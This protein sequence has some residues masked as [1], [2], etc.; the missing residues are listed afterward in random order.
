MLYSIPDI[1]A[2]VPLAYIAYF[3][4]PNTFDSLEDIRAVCAD[5]TDYEGQCVHKM[6]LLSRRT[7][8]YT[9]R[10]LGSTYNYITGED[11]VSFR[12]VTY[13]FALDVLFV[14]TY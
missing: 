1:T 14:S 10:A 7:W 11:F 4:S 3:S 5:N 13:L 8:Y 9:R 12:L 6:F 2:E